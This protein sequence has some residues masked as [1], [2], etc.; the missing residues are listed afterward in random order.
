MRRLQAPLDPGSQMMSSGLPPS[1]Q[2]P[3]SLFEIL[4]AFL[5]KHLSW[6]WVEEVSPA[7]LSGSYKPGCSSFVV[8]W[9]PSHIRFFVT[10]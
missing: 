10:P 7:S 6:P 4:C 2:F 8:V 5:H 3:R 1:C 9:S